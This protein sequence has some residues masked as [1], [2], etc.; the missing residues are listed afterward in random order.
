VLCGNFSRGTDTI[1]GETSD[2]RELFLV[3]DCQ[4]TEIEYIVH[5]VEVSV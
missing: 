3:D 4:D 5:K 1:L 2:P